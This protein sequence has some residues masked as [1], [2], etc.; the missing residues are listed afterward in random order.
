MNVS[1]VV[2]EQTALSE[3]DE[4]VGSRNFDMHDRLAN[5]SQA[6]HQPLNLSN[7]N[8]A[9]KNLLRDRSG[10]CC[11]HS[12]QPAIGIRSKP[13]AIDLGG[14]VLHQS[15][16]TFGGRTVGKG[17]ERSPRLSRSLYLL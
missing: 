8:T 16:C 17:V 14:I 10:S 7:V 15:A 12:S 1:P 3:F 6:E 13:G 4:T 11:D 5:N 9:G 2:D